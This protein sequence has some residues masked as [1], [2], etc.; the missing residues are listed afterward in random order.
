MEASS[1][2]ELGRGG[3]VPSQVVE[4]EA[5]Q[6]TPPGSGTSRQIYSNSFIHFFATHV[7]CEAI[8]FLP[9][10]S[11]E[12]LFRDQSPCG[13]QRMRWQGRGDLK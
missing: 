11:A 3:K 8:V 7:Y 4:G 12:T 5:S 1:E 10:W 6:R 13:V 2:P 9:V